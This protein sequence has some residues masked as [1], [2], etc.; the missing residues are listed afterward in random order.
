MDEFPDTWCYY[1]T[2]LCRGYDLDMTTNVTH[3]VSSEIENTS[4]ASTNFDTIS[5]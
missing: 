4:M 3:P 1:L 2:E 5:Y